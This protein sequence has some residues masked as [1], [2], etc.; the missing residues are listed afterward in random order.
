MCLGPRGF[1]HRQKLISRYFL[2]KLGY[3]LS[4]LL[5]LVV[6]PNIIVISLNLFPFNSNFI[7]FSYV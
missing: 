2:N 4:K 6:I 5:K 1:K 7:D 3:F